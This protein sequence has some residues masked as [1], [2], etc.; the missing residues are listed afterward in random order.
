M[1]F[2]AADRKKKG[3]ASLCEQHRL[4]KK[5]KLDSSH[6][7]SRLS[8]RTYLER[9]DAQIEDTV[10]KEQVG[11]TWM[12][13]APFVDSPSKSCTVVAD[14]ISVP[15]E[16]FDLDNLTEVLSYEVSYFICCYSL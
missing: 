3:S 12:D 6:C 13:M 7:M 1:T 9:N 2:Q 5:K 15:L 8:P 10:Q 16:I 4:K 11:I 14:E